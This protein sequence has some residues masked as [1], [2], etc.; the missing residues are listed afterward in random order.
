MH[1]EKTGNKVTDERITIYKHKTLRNYEMA[2]E[3][4]DIFNLSV[5]VSHGYHIITLAQLT[6]N[7]DCEYHA[8]G[9]IRKGKHVRFTTSR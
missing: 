1:G 2:A 9:S 3:Q 6:L 7:R 5:S 8:T 4:V